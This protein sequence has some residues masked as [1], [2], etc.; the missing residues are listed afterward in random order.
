[1]KRKTVNRKLTEPT[2]ID[3]N[4]PGLQREEWLTNVAVGVRDNRYVMDAFL[5]EMKVVK[6]TAKY[7]VY[8]ANGLF[9]SLPRRAETALPEQSALQYSEDVYVAEEYAGEGWVSDDSVRNSAPDIKPLTDEADYL[10]RKLLLTQ[11]VLVV[12]ELL[13]AIKASGTTNYTQ[14]GALTRWNGGA[15]AVI[16]TDLSNAIIQIVKN[17]GTRPNTMGLDTETFEAVIDNTA[18][19]ARLKTTSDKS[20][21]DTM[22]ITSLR[23]LRIVLADSVINTG[24]RDTASYSNILYDIDTVT[25]LRQSVIIAYLNPSDKLTLGHN[26]VP[27]P[28]RAF[29]GRG[30]EGDRRQATLVAVWKKLAPKVTNAGSAHLIGNVLGV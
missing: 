23:G 26:F 3:S 4:T 11:E 29:K 18:V 21:T 30:L 9:K 25:P 7:R 2:Q 20:V 28:Y 15:N 5:P 12:N 8:S 14:L 22:P 24:T 6:D 19:N 27:K 13:T 1:M 17:I 16:L 10:T